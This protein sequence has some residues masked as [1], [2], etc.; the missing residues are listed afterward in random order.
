M[1]AIH[2][3]PELQHLDDLARAGRWRDLHVAVDLL[4]QE[5]I[6]RAMEADQDE[7]FHDLV[8]GKALSRIVARGARL[9]FD[10]TRPHIPLVWRTGRPGPAVAAVRDPAFGSLREALFEAWVSAVPAGGARLLVGDVGSREFL[11]YLPTEDIGVAERVGTAVIRRAA[12]LGRSVTVGI[13]PPCPSPEY[14][15]GH[16]ERARWTAEV[17]QLGDITGPIATFDD[18]GIYALL[19]KPDRADE[20]E[21][22]MRRWIGALIDYDEKRKADLTITLGTLLEGRGL[23]QA[24]DQLVIHVSTLKYRIKR[25]GEILALD[26]HDPEVAFNLALAVRLFR[27]SR[28]R[29]PVA[30]AERTLP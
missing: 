18:I 4:V 7:V 23:R 1:H 8:E 25:I 6:S 12:G 2:S 24:A 15:A 28:L 17:L 22:F 11:A 10:L 9:G 27:I 26:Y 30:A 16:A 3:E 14:F 19:F 20:L 29:G 21:Q 13:G 5:R